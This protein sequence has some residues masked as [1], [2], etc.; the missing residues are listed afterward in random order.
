MAEDHVG[1]R[2]EVIDAAMRRLPREWIMSGKPNRP[3]RIDPRYVYLDTMKL[4]RLRL[5]KGWSERKLAVEV[6]IEWN[7]MRA[8]C[9]G[10]RVFASTAKKLAEGLGSEVADLLAEYDPRYVPSKLAESSLVEAEW[11]VAEYLGPG[12][13]ASN[14]LHWFIC[15]MQHRSI[16]SRMGRGKFYHLSFL[17]TDDAEKTLTYVGRHGEVSERIGPHRHVAE[18]MTQYLLPDG[19]GAWVV[20]R[21]IGGRMLSDWLGSKPLAEIDLKRVM[22]EVALGLE[23]L[24][25]ADIV[26]R[27]LSPERVLV[28]DGDGRAVLTDFELAKLLDGAPTVSNEWPEDDYRAP[29]V[30]SGEVDVRADLYSWARIVVRAAAGRLPKSG[31]EAEALLM[32]ASLP[33]GVARMALDCLAPDAADR[34]SGIKKVLRVV[35]RWK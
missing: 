10:K 23:A 29:E 15:R 1:T 30:E 35:K 20:D 3:K 21:W 14:G 13:M 18:N 16:R 2:M 24:H 27:E 17:P 4:Q 31:E 9:A 32:K 8:V 34:P 28:A 7:T 12:V 6:G 25:K 22:T 5:N 33:K 19:A 11:E 26:Y